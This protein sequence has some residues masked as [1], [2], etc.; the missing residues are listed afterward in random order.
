VGG[1]LTV[2]EATSK[3]VWVRSGDGRERLVLRDGAELQSARTY[4]RLSEHL[5]PHARKVLS[6]QAGVPIHDRADL[7]RYLKATGKHLEEKGESDAPAVA[8]LDDWVRSGGE[9]SG[10]ALP[11]ELEFKGWGTP[12]TDLRQ[13]YREL[14]GEDISASR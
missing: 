13:L 3:Y 1:G 7:R 6:A 14:H 12:K 5:S 2:P 11:K 4:A 10:R 8:A 9:S